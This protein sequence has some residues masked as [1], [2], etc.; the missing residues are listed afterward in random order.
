MAFA[1]ARFVDSLI[2]ASIYKKQNVTECTYINCDIVDGL[3]YFSAIVELGPNGVEKYTLPPLND[4][5]KGLL[6]NALPELQKSITQGVEF[7]SK[8]L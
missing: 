7:V 8:A 5:E 4:Y 6:S 3:E 2:Q 1:G